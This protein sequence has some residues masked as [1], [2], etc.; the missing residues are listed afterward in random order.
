MMRIIDFAFVQF[1]N[2]WNVFKTIQITHVYMFIRSPTSNTNLQFQYHL[3][4]SK[5]VHILISCWDP[6][7]KTF[8]MV[9]VALFLN[10]I[11]QC[12]SS[13]ERWWFKDL[14]SHHAKQSI[15][16][17]LSKV[18]LLSTCHM[19]P[20][21]A[22]ALLASVRIMLTGTGTLLVVATF[23]MMISVSNWRPW[24]SNQRGDSDM[25]LE[26]TTTVRCTLQQYF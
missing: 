23:S 18:G 26:E 7:I 9:S 25:S 19:F 14:K 8:T 22:S 6:T 21:R 16:V 17:L 11:L 12:L 15:S 20:E 24:L 2:S 5:Q 13:I 3:N 1:A 10:F 4:L